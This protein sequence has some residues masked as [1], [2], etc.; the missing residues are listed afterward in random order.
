M[1]HWV[2]SLHIHAHISSTC[3]FCGKGH[4]SIGQNAEAPIISK[5]E[6]RI[7]IQTCKAMASWMASKTNSSSSSVHTVQFP[8]KFAQ[9]SRSSSTDILTVTSASGL[10]LSIVANNTDA[11]LKHELSG[12]A[13]DFGVPSCIIKHKALSTGQSCLI[14]LRSTSAPLQEGFNLEA[15][16]LGWCK[17]GLLQETRECAGHGA[18]AS[19]PGKQ[20]LAIIL[21]FIWLCTIP[22]LSE[23]GQSS[24]SKLNHLHTW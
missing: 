7:S 22:C 3:C 18:A 1:Q 16:D 8:T 20:S 12:V 10:H 13:C 9:T 2:S 14:D 4:R 19:F 24:K 5:L 17:P 15:F 6:K 11:L 21:I 23:W